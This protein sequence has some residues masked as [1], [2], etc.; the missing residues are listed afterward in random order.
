MIA[1]ISPAQSAVDETIST[2]QYAEQASGIHN[3]LAAASIHHVS[4]LT[5]T[6]TPTAD[7][8]A[9]GFGDLTAGLGGS[10]AAGGALDGCVEA[11]E[12]RIEYLTQEVEE[13]RDAFERKQKE[14]HELHAR[15]D[16]SETFNQ[17]LR[18][19]AG[20]LASIAGTAAENANRARGGAEAAFEAA[21]EQVTCSLQ[22]PLK[23]L[24]DAL[25][26]DARASDGRRAFA[27]Q[28]FSQAQADEA[29]AAGHRESLREAAAVLAAAFA[30][31]LPEHAAPLRRLLQGLEEVLTVRDGALVEAL[32]F[33]ATQLTG[34]RAQL[35]DSGPRRQAALEAAFGGAEMTLQ[36]TLA[37][38][39]EDLAGLREEVAKVATSLREEG[40]L[41][42][43]AF[44]RAES[45]SEALAQADRE[46]EVALVAAREA[47]AN[48]V[49]ALQRQRA[50]EQDMVAQLTT[51]REALAADIERMQASLSQLTISSKA[52]EARL[53]ATR[54]EQRQSR[55]R[56]LGAALRGVEELLRAEFNALGQH[57][58]DGVAP[59][60]THLEEVSSLSAE[61]SATACTAVSQ[62]VAA[63]V[64]VAETTNAWASAGEAAC[65]GI[66]VAERDAATAS[67][68]C[69]DAASTAVQRL[70]Q[71]G[72]SAR[73]WADAC[74]RDSDTLDQVKSVANRVLAS[75]ETLPSQWATSKEATTAVARA[76]VKDGADVISV[77]DVAAQQRAT[78]SEEASALSHEIQVHRASAEQHVNHWASDEETH[79]RALAECTQLCAGLAGAE[80]ARGEARREA[81][82]VLADDF[83]ATATTVAQRVDEVLQLATAA[84]ECA[85]AVA[86]D[87]EV[88]SGALAATQAAV[89]D[90]KVRAE[91][92]AARST[93]AA[94]AAAAVAW[95]SVRGVAVEAPCKTEAVR[96]SPREPVAVVGPLRPE[97]KE[98]GPP[99]RCSQV[100]RGAGKRWLAEK[101]A[102]GGIGPRPALRELQPGAVPGLMQ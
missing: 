99:A 69:R 22:L 6:A 1:T 34:A 82:G 58:E 50:V 83:A 20:A 36:G 91:T 102:G 85:A 60:Q 76:W 29:S 78:A 5:P 70:H 52:A 81:L 53:A 9:L 93:G 80:A 72:D 17:E 57:F 30:E 92:I 88:H 86:T 19:E 35:A 73:S 77:L 100:S 15:L 42:T 48:E 21:R 79:Q 28:A 41:A 66:Q 62:A 10:G 95:T 47:V 98:N 94:D 97:I 55:T 23:A 45:A 24:G 37:S 64:Q 39:R 8:R 16:A 54:E 89:G 68:A 7:Q 32:A 4:R 67:Q 40:V 90:V 75:Q 44:D 74:R 14:I 13:A 87:T 59:I 26:A 11:L 84:G 49:A 63:S 101:G 43:A 27:G 51:Q 25:A 96:P 12:M 3:K 18:A 71:A 31:A 2:L 61:A 38:S 65:K 56:A 33:L 46:K